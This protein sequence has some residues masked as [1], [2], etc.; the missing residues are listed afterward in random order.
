MDYSSITYCDYNAQCTANA[1]SFIHPA[2][3]C[4]Y[5][6]QLSVTPESVTLN[7]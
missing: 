3:K 1:L 4:E 5:A 6:M 2:T 7:S